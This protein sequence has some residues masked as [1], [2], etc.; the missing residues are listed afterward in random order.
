MDRATSHQLLQQALCTTEPLHDERQYTKHNKLEQ[1]IWR[2][3]VPSTVE[4]WH[5]KPTM[6]QQPRYDFACE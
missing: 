2:A 1:H 5:I 3:L 6:L 4:R